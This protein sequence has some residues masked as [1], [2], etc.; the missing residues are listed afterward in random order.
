MKQTQKTEILAPAG[1]Y[2][3]MTA[4]IEAGADAVYI[5]G[6]RFGARAFA[7]NLDEETML[8]AIDYAHLHQV[9]LYMTVNTLMKETEL[10]ELYSYLLP[11]Y[12]RG[13]D[14][15][16]VQDLGAFFKIR[17]CFL[18]LPVHAS[19]QMTITGVQG[20]KL[21]AGM[22]AWRV[23]TARE[24]SLEEI[25]EI[26][27]ELPELEIES[28]VHGALCYCY[29]GQ[30]LLSSLIGGR[31]GNRGRCAQPCRLPYEVKENGK[32]LNK[33]DEKYILSPKDLCVLDIL[34]ELIEA[35]IYSLK[36]E[37]RMKS[38]RY[39]AGVVRM[40][41]KYVDAYYKDGKE[42]YHVEAADR[43]E[44]LDLFDRGGQTEGYYRQHNGR[45]M[46]TLKEKPA[47]R[48]TNQ[49]L[50]DFL[51]KT[52]VEK[53]S[54]IGISGTVTVRE[55]EPLALTLE[56][57]LPLENETV[58]V[59]VY[60]DMVQAAKNQ[61]LTAD[62]IRTQMQKT[63]N[64]VFFWEN[65]HVETD[66]KSFLPMQALNGLRRLGMEKLEEAILSRYR[67]KTEDEKE[68]DE[69]T[70]QEKIEQEKTGPEDAGAAETTAAGDGDA[71]V[72]RELRLSVLL[73]EIEGFSV[74]LEEEAV[75]RIY[76]AVDSVPAERFAQYVTECHKRGKACYLALPQIFRKEAGDFLDTKWG[77]IKTAGFD[78]ML[79][80]SLEELGYLKEKG[81][82]LPVVADHNLYTWSTQA[83]E[84]Y[85]AMGFSE[86]TLPVELNQKE[87]QRRGCE[88]SEW[89]VY[90]RLPVMVSAQCIVKTT[91]GCTRK[92]ERLVIKDR[93][94]KEFP[95]K[96]HCAF[97]YNTI[98]NTSPLSLLGQS[99]TA[100]KLRVRAVRLQFS[101]ETREEI[102]RITAAF[103][104]AFI[105]RKVVEEPV[106]DYTRG[107][108]KRG[109]E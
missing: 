58:A 106:E 73:E 82:E 84:V 47:F 42:K 101:V 37:G 98:Y 87:L 108:F 22:G 57:S 33:K 51:D 86:D 7:N 6:S 103:A 102:K 92:P 85:Q 43:R 63:G 18:D 99:R 24:L 35:G 79:A 5:G 49:K 4:A 78:G 76:L 38:P 109:V 72:Q 8:R 39:T 26:H 88:G 25:R 30:C 44:L 11:F 77:M 45:D 59:T 48:E 32:T 66:E 70:E 14:A 89:I 105:R 23:V 15:V 65:L 97:C 40:Y 60:G 41:R 29:S 46:I 64:S 62:R 21:L 1:S 107:H 81:W 17:E 94:G 100:E 93:I 68:K 12:K 90:G 69:K 9:K 55:G 13:L 67:R 3:S 80:G 28:F 10:E 75:S 34:P 61:P 74:V 31:S 2:E 71:K 36:I 56:K 104:D 20:A 95:V 83:R 19:T 54:Q 50:F 91:K 27:R 53:Q 16:I 96:N 52:Y